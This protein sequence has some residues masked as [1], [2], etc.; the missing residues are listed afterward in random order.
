MAVLSKGK[1]QGKHSGLLQKARQQGDAE[2]WKPTKAGD[3]IAGEVVTLNTGG[4]FNS[5]FYHLRAESDGVLIVAASPTT[6]LGKELANLDVDV[7]DLLAIVFL[8]KEMGKN[9]PYKSWSCVC[10]KPL[11][12]R[13]PP[14]PPD[15][16][17]I[18]GFA[19]PK[20]AK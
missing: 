2:F 8:G 18:P 7:G 4:K 16:D 14:P 20:K 1:L 15:D 11:T 5:T 19:I 17:E 13:E 12:E 10:Q 6:V 9:G 3:E